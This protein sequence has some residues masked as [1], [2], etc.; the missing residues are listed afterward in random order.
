MFR[1]GLGI[2]CLCALFVAWMA[3]ARPL[4]MMLDRLHTVE[5]ESQ[6]ITR[7]G[8]VDAE[9]GMLQVNELPMSTATPEYRPYP[10]EMKLNPARQFVAQKLGHAIVLGR[11]DESLGVNP[12]A[13]DKARLRIERSMLSW[14]TPLAINFMTGHSP[15]WKRHLYYRLTWEKPD[16]GRLEMVWR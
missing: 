3:G 11:V 4:S 16:G 13:G 1:S 12:P 9:R 10:M 14:P 6:A 2:T 8:V 5:I 15:S 7:L